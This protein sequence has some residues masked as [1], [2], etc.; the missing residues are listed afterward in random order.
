MSNG[1]KILIVALC[2][3]NGVLQWCLGFN[4]G[5]NTVRQEAIERK[6][7]VMDNGFKWKGEFVLKGD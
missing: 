3:A 4:V 7:A 2:F 6:L 1:M 5:R